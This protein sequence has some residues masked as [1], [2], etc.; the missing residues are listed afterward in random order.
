LPK[1][2]KRREKTEEENILTER[3]PPKHQD[4]ENTTPSPTHN[5]AKV[6][7]RDAD[8]AFK[9]GMAPAAPPTPSPDSVKRIGFSLASS[10]PSSENGR[11]HQPRLLGVVEEPPHYC[12]QGHHHDA[13]GAHSHKDRGRP[14]HRGTTD[15]PQH[16][17]QTSPRHVGATT[18]GVA[19]AGAPTMEAVGRPRLLARPLESPTEATRGRDQP[20]GRSAGHPKG[21][22]GR[23]RPEA[24]RRRRR[25]STAAPSTRRSRSGSLG[26][27]SGLPQRGSGQSRPGHTKNTT[28]MAAT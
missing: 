25:R 19:V 14:S 21:G 16:T 24:S 8:V 6:S 7:G 10:L 1:E 12:R 3:P 20:Q 18:A 11:R 15:Q 5:R 22:H 26:G 17:I 27:G 4:D 13:E 23:G 9:K 2:R 28:A